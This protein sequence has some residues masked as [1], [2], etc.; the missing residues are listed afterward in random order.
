MVITKNGVVNR[1]RV[2]EIRTIGRATQGVKLMNL[3]EGDVVVDTDDA[4]AFARQ[5]AVAAR[6]H[7]IDLEEVV[8]LDDDLESVFRYLV[9]P[10]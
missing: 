1:Q 4:G 3:D 2:S 8:P 10:R 9:D 5:V 6:R 7:D